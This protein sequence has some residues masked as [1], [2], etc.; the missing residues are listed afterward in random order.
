M[1]AKKRRSTDSV[2]EAR[3]RYVDQPN[4]WI[5]TTPSAK[6]REQEKAWRALEASFTKKKKAKSTRT[7]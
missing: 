3:K 2:K 4:Q 1:V 5:D 6:K 7:K